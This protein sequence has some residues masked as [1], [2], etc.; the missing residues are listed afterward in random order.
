FTYFLDDPLVG[1]AFEQRD[2]RRIYGLGIRGGE[3]TTPP[4]GVI[5]L[6][7]GADLRY[8]DIDNLGLY[9]TDARVR[10][11]TVRQDRIEE[12]SLGAWGESEWN[13]T[14]RLRLLLGLRGDWYDWD[15]NAFRAVNSG[16]G[17]D[18]IWSPKAAIAWRF[19]DNFEAYVNYGRGFHSNDVRGATISVDP[20]TGAPAESVPVLVRSEGGELGLRFERSRDFNATLTF[21]WLELDSELVFVGDAGATEASDGTERLG[22]EAALFWQANDWLALNTA[23]AVTNAEYQKDQSGGREIPGAVESTFTLGLNAVWDNGISASARV[24]WLGEA[25]LVEDN[26][27][28]H[29]ESLLVNAAVAYRRGST[30]FRLDVFNL[31]DSSDND[32]AYFYA[33]RLPGE[34]SAGIEDIHFH[35]L[36]PRSIRGSVTWH[37]Q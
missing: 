4:A 7:W 8:D 21:F 5:A 36:E 11:S 37:W 20:A 28:R 16:A 35:P 31:L 33:S 15:V 17:D 22:F 25:P 19:S 29:D 13:V 12:L 26:S 1:D 6:R 2:D 24:R 18:S 3:E 23:Y 34:A 14:E 10:T 9:R 30:E 32:I 27:V